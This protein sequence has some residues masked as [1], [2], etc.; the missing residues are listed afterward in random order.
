[1]KANKR[2]S[3][4]N[5]RRVCQKDKE[6]KQQI[7]ELIDRK[8]NESIVE[9]QIIEYIKFSYTNTI[10]SSVKTVHFQAV[11]VI[12][13]LIKGLIKHSI[14]NNSGKHSMYLI[15]LIMIYLNPFFN[16]FLN[17]TL[18]HFFINNI[19]VY[20]Y[21][22]TEDE[23]NIIVTNNLKLPILNYDSLSFLDFR[24]N[25]M[26]YLKDNYTTAI[27]AKP[28]NNNLLVN[29]DLLLSTLNLKLS[30]DN[31]IY[32]INT[33]IDSLNDLMFMG[34][35]KINRGYKI[36]KYHA[37]VQ[38]S[39]YLI[40]SLLEH[41]FINPSIKP[42]IVTNKMQSDTI[43]IKVIDQFYTDSM[44]HSL[45]F[46]ISNDSDTI[47]YTI[48]NNFYNNHN[49][50]HNF[51]GNKEFDLEVKDNNNKVISRT[52]KLE[53]K[54]GQGSFG[55]IYKLKDQAVVIK[56]QKQKY[57]VIEYHLLKGLNYKDYFPN[58]SAIYFYNMDFS[59]L[60][61]DYYSCPTLLQ[62][63]NTF[64]VKKNNILNNVI[65]VILHQLIDAIQYLHMNWI[66]HNDIK[67]DNI[68]IDPYSRYSIK[69]IDFG[70]AI[71]LK[72][73]SS[74]TSIQSNTTTLLFRSRF[75]TDTLLRK[76]IQRSSPHQQE[77]KKEWLYHE[78][79]FGIAA[80]LYT[81][82]MQQHLKRF[83]YNKQDQLFKAKPN[84]DM[85]LKCNYIFN[86]LTNSD[87]FIKS[88]LLL[89]KKS[90][91]ICMKYLFEYFYPLLADALNTEPE[92]N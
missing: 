58:V 20:C 80:I 31:I 43:T 11:N 16:P 62:Y 13:S 84:F 64:I 66:L 85:N 41:L 46:K 3:N 60:F 29:L 30:T 74:F 92:S 65:E 34:Y 91:V 27:C 12:R 18:I 4:I 71:D 69:V 90:F 33:N 87:Y 78:D 25:F 53:K 81:L 77:L 6:Y 72:H 68:L 49:L 50:I 19:L 44:I 86:L 55:K 36:G 37:I 38:Y 51:E 8:E 21:N 32:F 35:D 42:I 79:L 59:L 1:M 73:S 47:C 82:K 76:N 2:I 45:K 67:M 23:P 63:L 10:Q 28:D 26:D 22:I 75:I 7:L 39:I 17:L 9:S 89:H 40:T 88:H 15:K 5:M 61:L 83:E 54:I 48:S 70:K 14:K 24:F 52:L 56:N 57:S